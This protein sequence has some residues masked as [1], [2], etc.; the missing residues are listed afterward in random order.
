ML[1]LVCERP[2]GPSLR[3]IET[4]AQ[5][6][7]LR[8]LDCAAPASGRPYRID[9]DVWD[10]L[11]CDSPDAATARVYRRG[12]PSIPARDLGLDDDGL[13]ALFRLQDAALDGHPVTIHRDV[14]A[15]PAPQTGLAA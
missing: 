8:L 3:I 14:Q 10:T 7:I 11:E 9:R 5:R 15:A 6:A 13:I 4:R 12:G 1:T 2:Q